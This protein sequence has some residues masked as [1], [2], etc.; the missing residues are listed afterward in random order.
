MEPT[1]ANHPYS[2]RTETSQPAYHQMMGG[3]CRLMHA[4]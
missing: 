3:S 2:N 4:I 1:T